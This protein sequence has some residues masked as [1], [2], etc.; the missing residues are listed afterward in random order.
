[1]E[2][3]CSICGCVYL[4]NKGGQLTNHLLKVHNLSF[5][6]YYVFSELEGC[7][8]ACEC[9]CGQEPEF[10]RGK[11]RK[12]AKGHNTFLFK[13]EQYKI[14]NGI[15]KCKTCNNDVVFYRGKPNQFCSFECSGKQTGFSLTE[16][17]NKI[18]QTVLEKY[19]VDN[20][21]KLDEVKHKISV[22]HI[23]N[24]RNH[25]VSDQTKLIMSS[26]SKLW[27]SNLTIEQRKQFCNKL[28]FSCNSQKEKQ[29]RKLLAVKHIAGKYFCVKNRFSKLH[30]KIR[31]ELNLEH[32][33]FVGE[34][35]IGRF[36]VDELNNDKKI[37][38]E[39]NGDYIHANPSKY[40]ADTLI[41][42]PG[43]SYYAEEKWF[44]DQIKIDKLKEMGYKVLVVWESDNLEEVKNNLHLLI[45]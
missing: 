42:L 30:L 8:P 13:E 25:K 21:S 37:I 5:K 15:P 34:Q 28:K 23:I 32:L 12:Y 45:T 18:K 35:R 11:F 14:K 38:I 9:G 10:Y 36:L 24:P 4:N 43:N 17:Q 3:K 26:N 29:R 22:S 1:M 7:P 16:T 20:V 2:T 31:K 44:T 40:S 19:G 33:G 27:W 39:I 41:R 6:D